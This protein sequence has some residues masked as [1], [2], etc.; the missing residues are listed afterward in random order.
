M[1]SHPFK[2]IP[3]GQLR[4]RM[5]QDLKLK[6]LSPSTSKVYLL[7]VRKFAMHYRRS[8]AELGEVDSG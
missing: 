7:Y 3:V 5:A 8:P 6:K 1:V 2:E 4:D